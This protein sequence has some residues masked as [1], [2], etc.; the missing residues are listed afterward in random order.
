MEL[1]KSKLIFHLPCFLSL[2]FLAI[3]GAYLIYVELKLYGPKSR[4]KG[5]ANRALGNDLQNFAK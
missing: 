3:E 5:K 4:K 2:S 1:L